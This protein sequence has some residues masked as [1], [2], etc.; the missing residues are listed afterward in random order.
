MG[1][2]LPDGRDLRAGCDLIF[3]GDSP[4]PGTSAIAIYGQFAYRKRIAHLIRR[5]HPRRGG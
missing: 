5:F 1:F 3:E 2:P 4:R